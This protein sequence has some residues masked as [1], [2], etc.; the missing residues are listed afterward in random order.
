MIRRFSLTSIVKIVIHTHTQTDT[1]SHTHTHVRIT[2]S[3]G[4][5]NLMRLQFV[6]S[7]HKCIELSRIL[8][9]RVGVQYIV[10]AVCLSVNNNNRLPTKLPIELSIPILTLITIRRKQIKISIVYGIYECEE[11]SK[12]KMF[13]EQQLEK[14]KTQQETKI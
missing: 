10:R 12:Y 6:Y 14:H 5:R 9:S 4:N 1:H 8:Y 2:W 11:L 3:V 13:V 7:P